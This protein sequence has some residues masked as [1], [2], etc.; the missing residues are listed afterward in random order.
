MRQ[1]CHKWFF[2]ALEKKKK[3]GNKILGKLVENSEYPRH[4][5]RGYPNFLPPSLTNILEKNIILLT[6]SKG[7]STKNKDK[8]FVSLS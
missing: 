8:K 3:L 7:D 2:H 5:E 6:A 4:M 1:R